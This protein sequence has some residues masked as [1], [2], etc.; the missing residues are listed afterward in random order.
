MNPELP[1]SIQTALA[2]EGVATAHPSADLLTAFAEHALSTGE[3]GQITD[4]L[5][6]CPECREVVFLASSADEQYVTEQQQAAMKASL[7]PRWT[8][9][10]RMAWIVSAAAGITIVGGILLQH[11]IAHHRSNQN[12]PQVAQVTTEQTPI[13]SEPDTS[14]QLVIAPEP[15]KPAQETKAKSSRTDNVLRQNSEMLAK[16]SAPPSEAESR[17]VAGIPMSSAVNE[18]SEI[19]VDGSMNGVKAAAPAQNTFAEHQESGRAHSFAPSPLSAT[20]RVLMRQPNA[21][22]TWRVTPEGHIEHFSQAGW[23]GV[24]AD[25]PAT[26]RVVSEFRNGVWAGGTCGEL[27]HSEDGGE[28]WSEI[29]LPAPPEDKNG[30]IVAIHFPDLQHGVIITESGLRYSTSDGG[31]NWK[32][33]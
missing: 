2:R 18:P 16:K 5:A 6:R 22:K 14:R 32:R 7:R 12:A 21:T 28:H 25:Q 24:L 4:H 33:E 17:A 1:K 23:T 10:P 15:R 26:F 27:F 29:V 11:Y 13:G 8:W 19:V 30:P 20:P 3:N 31:K 9:M